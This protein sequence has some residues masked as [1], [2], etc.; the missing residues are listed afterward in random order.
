MKIHEQHDQMF[1]V[2]HPESPELDPEGE[3]IRQMFRA[4]FGDA[5]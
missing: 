5:Y 3:P 2:L 1:N 4:L